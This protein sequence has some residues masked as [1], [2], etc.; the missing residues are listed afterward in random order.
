MEKLND[1]TA[2]DKAITWIEQLPVPT[3]GAAKHGRALFLL[4]E[5]L[6]KTSQAFREP[7][8]RAEAAEAKLAELANQ[9]PVAYT[10][11]EELDIMQKGTYADMFKPCDEYKSDPKW[12]PLFTRA[13]PAADLADLVPDELTTDGIITMH[14]CGVVEGWNACRTATLRNIEEQTK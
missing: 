13:A 8:Q 9:P 5:D 6:N 10:D 7:E 1:L 12:I 11:A 3:A 4:R 2:L 14:E